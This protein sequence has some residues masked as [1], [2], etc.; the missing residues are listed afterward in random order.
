[1]PKK[2]Y[3]YRSAAKNK[4]VF[5]FLKTNSKLPDIHFIS[6]LQIFIHTLTAYALLVCAMRIGGKRQI[7]ELQITELVTAFMLSEVATLPLSSDNF[8]LIYSA[9]AIATVTGAEILIAFLQTKSKPLRT[10]LSGKPS[11]VIEKG[12]LNIREMKKL[13]MSI[14]ELISE[15]RLCGISDVGELEYAILEDNGKLSVFTK[16]DLGGKGISHVIIS[17]GQI[18]EFGMRAAKLSRD[19]LEKR[20]KKKNLTASSVFLYTVNDRGEEYIVLKDG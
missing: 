14:E 1:M 12:K 2:E 5:R 11:A 9:V 13:R 18:N 4:D 17:A 7:G 8:P 16:K 20:L 3:L 15:A 19:Q 10:L 6:M